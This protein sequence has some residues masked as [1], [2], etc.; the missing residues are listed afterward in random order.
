MTLAQ[1]VSMIT[2]STTPWVIKRMRKPSLMKVLAMVLVRRTIVSLVR[3]TSGL[4]SIYLLTHIW[5]F[6]FFVLIL[7][8]ISHCQKFHLLLVSVL[9][10]HV[11]ESLSSHQHSIFWPATFIVWLITTS[12]KRHSRW[13]LMISPWFVLS[14]ILFWFFLLSFMIW[15]FSCVICDWGCSPRSPYM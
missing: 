2:S 4:S 5:V 10:S 13:K 15:F 3:Y 9:R 11:K 8:L 6:L 1:H 14:N 7:Q 12:M